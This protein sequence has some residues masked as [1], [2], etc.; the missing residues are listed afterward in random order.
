MSFDFYEQLHTSKLTPEKLRQ[1]CGV[2]LRTFQRWEKSNTCPKYAET[3]ITCYSYN[4]GWLNKDWESSYIGDRDGQ[5]WI[6]DAPRP[7]S[8]TDIL[9]IYHK[10]QWLHWYY[11]KWE[12]QETEKEATE[13]NNIIQFEMPFSA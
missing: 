9:I 8:K 5:L 10:W 7:Y 3:I 4:L 1:L 2:T 12:K 13:D 11:E 6:K